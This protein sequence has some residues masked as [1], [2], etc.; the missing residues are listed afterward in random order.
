MM[1]LSFRWYGHEDPVTLQAIRQI[2][3]IKEIVFAQYDAQPGNPWDRAVLKDLIDAITNHG[4]YPGVIE[5]IPVAESIKL[6]N[7]NRD[8]AIEAWIASMTLCA[9]LLVPFEEVTGHKPVITYNFMPVFDWLRTNL[10][11]RLADGS[12]TLAYEQ[13]RIDTLN[14]T[15]SDFAL[16]G[17]IIDK[18]MTD[19]VLTAYQEITEATL[20]KNLLYFLNAVVPYAEKAGVVLALH[21]DDPPWSVFGLPRIITGKTILERLFTDVPSPVNGLCF[22]TGSF[23]STANNDVYELVENFASRIYFAHLR[24]VRLLQDKSFIETAHVSDAGNIDMAT[25]VYMLSS[26]ERSLPVRPDHGR[27]IW[28]ETGKP[29]YGLYDRALGAMYLAGLIEMAHKHCSCTAL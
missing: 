12:T 5:S 20:Y 18:A 25:I 17:W 26:L 23:G 10:A 19:T 24:N 27:M 8:A 3:V 7:Q 4:F 15:D 13:D 29:G 6:G 1:T 9:E 2:P 28:G 22:C 11:Y 16:P 14:P 21:P